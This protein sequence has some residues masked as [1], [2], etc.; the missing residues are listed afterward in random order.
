MKY[1]P[2][3]RG[4]YEDWGVSP[5]DCVFVV[6]EEYEKLLLEA[7][8]SGLMIAPNEKGYPVLV[9]T[10]ELELTYDQELTK[11]NNKFD[12]LFRELESSLVRSILYG[13][14]DTAA[15]IKNELQEEYGSLVEKRASAV[16]ELKQKYGVN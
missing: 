5:D 11:V 13:E 1:S 12:I 14:Y 3:T 16:L 9:P 8:N 2:S 10:P 4:F 6:N 15:S 7:A